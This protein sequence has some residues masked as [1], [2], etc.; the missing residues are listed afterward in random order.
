MDKFF[1]LGLVIGRYNHIHS[2]HTKI[3][4][5]SIKLC[6][7]TL[8]LIG[9]AQES[10]TI[11]NP[12]TLETRKKVIEKI[13]NTDDV[14][15]GALNDYTNEED[16]SPKWGRFIL[17]NVKREYGIEPDLMVYGKEESRKGWFSEEDN[18]NFSELLI[19]RDKNMLSAT[20]LRKYMAQDN[21]EEWK[22]FV[23][24]EIWDMYE[25]LREELV[26]I[27]FYKNIKNG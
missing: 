5:Q 1:K 27:E 24:N 17:D 8:I 15:I 21:K 26:Q 25:E 16:I 18:K 9:S 10:G 12:F 6:E 3:I 2:G 7:K 14:I 22:K 19:V 23:P 11:R 13:Y 20:E 4:N